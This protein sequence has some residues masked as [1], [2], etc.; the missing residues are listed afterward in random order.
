MS[1]RKRV[2]PPNLVPHPRYGSTP[3]PSGLEIPEEEIRSGFW[4]NRRERMFPESVLIADAAKQNFA[5]Y[6]RS[7]YVDVLREC[8][9]CLRPFI[10]FAAEQRHWFE[11]LRFYVDADCVL[12]PSCRRD[13]QSLRRRLRRYS[14]TLRKENPTEREFKFLVDDGAYLLAR[15]VLRDLNSLGHLKNR[16]AKVIP[17]Y[18]GLGVL[19][20]AIR[21]AKHAL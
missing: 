19:A 17:E 14:D 10:F 9:N 7:Y 12:C 11:T 21:N 18:V 6:P 15:G 2:L 1:H 3:R 5:V 13:T 20:E 4:R 16:A 8:Q